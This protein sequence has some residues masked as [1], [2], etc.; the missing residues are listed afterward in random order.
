M[1]DKNPLIEYIAKRISKNLNAIIIINGA[2]GSGKSY[3]TLD[4]A[5]SLSKRLDSPFSIENN[6]DF[7]FE[8]LLRKT[9]RPENMK[10]GT[11]F[12]F[13]EVGAIGGGAAAREWQSKAN[14]FFQSFMQTARH[15]N[16]IFIM[17]CPLFAFLE[18]GTRSLVH[19]QITMRQINQQRKQSEGKPFIIQTNTITGKQYFKYLRYKAKRG[20]MRTKLGFVKFN[21]PPKEILDVYEPMKQK[22]SDTLDQK[23]LDGGKPKEKPLSRR[24]AVGPEKLRKDI[25]D[26]LTNN[27][28]SK[29]YGCSESTIKYWLR[30]FDIKRNANEIRQNPLGNSGFE[31]RGGQTPPF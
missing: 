26:G 11:V 10:P 27:K 15:R 8:N 13:E 21:L 30:D 18:K 14:S 7:S 3:A 29:K 23:I 9:K 19:I 5:A 12:V 22:Y 16:Q 24:D 28:I 1:E 6:M 17:T 25:E 20:A 31:G 2:T 4:M